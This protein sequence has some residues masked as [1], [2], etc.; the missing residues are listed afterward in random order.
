MAKDLKQPMV[1]DLMRV[2]YNAVD[3][4]IYFSD[5]HFKVITDN[6]I[7]G[8]VRFLGISYKYIPRKV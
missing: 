2:Y 8:R 4:G 7:P 1:K 6:I 3:K 5:T